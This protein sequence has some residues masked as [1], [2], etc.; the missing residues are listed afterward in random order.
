MSNV[1]SQNGQAG[2]NRGF[3]PPRERSLQ[4]RGCYSSKIKGV[5]IHSGKAK[6]TIRLQNFRNL[7]SGSTIPLLGLLRHQFKAVACDGSKENNEHR[8]AGDA[9]HRTLG[10]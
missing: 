3:W 2:M 10:R 7:D 4:H 6:I 5:G 1:R 8:C 9:K